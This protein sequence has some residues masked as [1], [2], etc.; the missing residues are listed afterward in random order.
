MFL[1]SQN[2]FHFLGRSKLRIYFPRMHY[3]QSCFYFY[4]QM[5]WKLAVR[6][7]KRSLKIRH[8]SSI[9]YIM[10]L[11]SI[12]HITDQYTIKISLLQGVKV[13]CTE[14]LPQV[15]DSNTICSHQTR[16]IKKLFLKILDYLQENTYVG[17]LF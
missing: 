14:C 6:F 17:V 9:F 1:V 10:N 12:F 15:P 7:Y 8:L 13:T 16:S 2:L 3:T 4:L 11:S 5:T